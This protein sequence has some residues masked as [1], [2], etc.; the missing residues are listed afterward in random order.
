MELPCAE[1]W[2]ILCPVVGF[3]QHQEARV[4]D[5]GERELE[6]LAL[7]AGEGVKTRIGL[8]REAEPPEEFFHGGVIAVE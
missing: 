5:E 2:N 1:A 3:V 4:V 8:P 7:A 6:A